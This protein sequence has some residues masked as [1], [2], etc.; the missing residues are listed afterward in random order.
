MRCI[1]ASNPLAVGI[2][3]PGLVLNQLRYTG[4]LDTLNIRRLGFPTRPKHLEFWKDFHVLET[5]SVITNFNDPNDIAQA[6]EVLCNSIKEQAADIAA[7]MTEAQPPQNQIDDPIRIGRSKKAGADPND[8]F[9]FIRDWLGREL[10]SARDAIYSK[11]AVIIQAYPAPTP[12]SR[13]HRQDE[14]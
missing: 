7:K 6:T 8:D 12:I 4:M 5:K 3:C 11:N 2:F 9:V 14:Y 1:K 13:H 10:A